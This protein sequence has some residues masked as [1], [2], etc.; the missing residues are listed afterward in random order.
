MLAQMYPEYLSYVAF[1]MDLKCVIQRLQKRF[2]RSQAAVGSDLELV[3]ANARIFNKPGTHEYIMAEKL[4]KIFPGIIAGDDWQAALRKVSSAEQG[5][6]RGQGSM[7]AD[8]EEAAVAEGAEGGKVNWRS[9]AR[10]SLQKFHR[11]YAGR[12]PHLLKSTVVVDDTFLPE[13]RPSVTHSSA[14]QETYDGLC[15]RVYVEPLMHLWLNCSLH[16]ACIRT[17]NMDMVHGIHGHHAR[18]LVMK[19]HDA[20]R[21]DQLGAVFI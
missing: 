11:L 15:V 17:H 3:V 5:Q 8:E 4:S 19:M 12:I 1:P 6:G 10:R 2:Y 9:T 7:L 13:V 14:H 21:W 16:S 20:C 18:I